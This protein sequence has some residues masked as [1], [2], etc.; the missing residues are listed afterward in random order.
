MNLAQNRTDLNKSSLSKVFISSLPTHKEPVLLINISL[1]SKGI[2]RL[3]CSEGTNPLHVQA[4]GRVNEGD[5][6]AHDPTAESVTF[7]R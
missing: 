7:G 1:W 6:E 4:A 5:T 2:K 3:K